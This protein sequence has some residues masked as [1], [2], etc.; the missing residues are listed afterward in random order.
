MERS[1][2][3]SSPTIG[4][5]LYVA[6]AVESVLAVAFGISYVGSSPTIGIFLYVSVRLKTFTDGN[7]GTC[8]YDGCA[9]DPWWFCSRLVSGL[10]WGTKVLLEN[11]PL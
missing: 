7:C 5:F 10:V 11:V 3:G 9:W 4:I 2:V 8:E 6:Q 1:Y